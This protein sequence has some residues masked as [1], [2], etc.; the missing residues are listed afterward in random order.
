VELKEE[1]YIQIVHNANR[2]NFNVQS[3]GYYINT[4]TNNPFCFFQ[5]P[6]TPKPYDQD[7]RVLQGFR[8]LQNISIA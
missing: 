2:S 5:S 8:G 3:P 7:Y 4:P 6:N 1:D